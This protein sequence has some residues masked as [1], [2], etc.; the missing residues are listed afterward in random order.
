MQVYYNIPDFVQAILDFKDDGVALAPTKQP[1]I[2]KDK[3]N[4]GG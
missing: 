1:E 4:Y 3:S 2:L